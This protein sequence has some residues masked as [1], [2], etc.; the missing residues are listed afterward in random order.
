M[1]VAPVLVLA[2]LLL[3][4]SA[5][6]AGP[7]TVQQKMVAIA[8]KEAR[9]NVQEVPTHSN[10]G[11]DIRRYHTAVKH[12]R[13]T[14]PW[15]AIFVSYVA[16]KAG[17]PLGSVSQGIWD[18]KNLFKWGRHE[19]F[20]FNKGA[21]KV[22]VGD[23]AV[24]GYGHSGIVV[25]VTKSG[26]IYTVDANWSDTVRYQPIPYLSVSGYIRLPSRPRGA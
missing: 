2:T 22:K 10:T 7:R 11:P 4:G 6:A 26:A 23:I 24:H 20:Y 12:A 3:A 1:K 14:E 16:K 19:G 8:L 13:T 21:R 9:R 18:I 15:C 5:Q 25:R 17:Y